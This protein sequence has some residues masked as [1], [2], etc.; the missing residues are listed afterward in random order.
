VTEPSTP[1]TNLSPAPRG[2]FQAGEPTRDPQNSPDRYLRVLRALTAEISRHQHPGP[3]LDAVLPLVAEGLGFEGGWVFLRREPDGFFLAS[4]YRVPPGLAA[5]SHAGLNWSPCRCQRRLLSGDPLISS[6]WQPCERL[7]RAAAGGVAGCNPAFHATVPLLA[8]DRV[9]GLMNLV[10]AGLEPPA[11]LTELLDMVGRLVGLALERTWVLA[12]AQAARRREQD[13]AAELARALLNVGTVEDLARALFP[14]LRRVL[15]PDGLSLLVVDPTGTYLTLAAGWGW[16]EAHVGRLQLP[17]RPPESS[18]PAWVIHTREP[19]LFELGNTARPFFVPEPVRRAG[20]RQSLMLPL[21]SGEQPVGV[22]AVNWFE[23]RP[24]SEDRIRF[25]G[26]LCQIAAGV[27]A[28]VLELQHLHEVVEE[29][30]IGSYRSTPDGRFVTVNE[31]LVKLLG[32]PDR[33][34]LLAT[35]VPAIYV[36]PRDRVRWQ[37]LIERRGT[38]TGFEV[39][40][41]RFDGT[42]IWVR[43]SARA[44]QDVSGRVAYYEGTVEDVTEKKQSEERARFLADHDPLTGVFNRRR[45]QA[46]LARRIY[47]AR[48][49]GRSGAV[50]FIDLDN[51]KAVNDLLGHQAGDQLLQELAAL[52]RSRLRRGEIL[53]RLGGDEFG[54]VLFPA[55]ADQAR[56]VAG[57]LLEAIRERTSLLG[58]GR[59]RTV[60]SCGIAV[61]PGQ[62]QTVDEVLAAADRALYAAK[63][64][65]GD[66]V[67]LCCPGTAWLHGPI[68]DEVSRALAGNGLEIF[69]QPILDLR[70]GQVTQ[71]ELLVRL[72]SGENLLKPAAFL[73]A[74]E[75]LGMVTRIDLKVLT[76][77]V[78]VAREAGLRLHVN[79]SG[80]TLNDREAIERMV[81]LL[82]E[83]RVDPNRVVLEI[84]EQTVLAD[85]GSV[86]RHL[87]TLRRRGYR[88]ALD[89]FGAGFSSFHYLRHLPVDYVKID[90]SL[91]LNLPNDVPAQKIVRAV[92]ALI[93]DL[94]G[95]TIVEW[96]EDEATL[97]TV[98]AL[99]VVD[100]QGFYI[101]KPVPVAEILAAEAPSGRESAGR[102]SAS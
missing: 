74:A 57:R 81:R 63:D 77:A 68:A 56:A 78:R 61:F 80:P 79:V 52:M 41:R 35:P 67:E 98:R 10:P 7:E 73:E 76:E 75:R 15:E 44:V 29:L 3:M 87:K 50:L 97:E 90:G 94:G 8:G 43:E 47:L 40:W 32:Y 53:A 49:T 2:D 93:R 65:G 17:L 28:R 85:L 30:P 12:E 46:E 24:A 5:D 36:D 25:A 22:V 27:L 20:V 86:R 70:S 55:D 19:A 69:A 9:T 89:D 39:R 37:R 31:A 60:A 45:F 11:G 38:L 1:G 84:T 83:A 88:L 13:E 92:A 26:L 33:A 34:T 14:F 51:F 100:A 71:Y 96:V 48:R 58:G 6:S 59:V 16:S 18:G 4:S 91:I 54:V 23:V 66:Q 99:G 82:E 21:F 62:A 42:P 95:A 102:K 101:G 72:R 64:R